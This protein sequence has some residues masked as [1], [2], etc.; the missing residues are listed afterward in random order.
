MNIPRGLVVFTVALVGIAGLIYWG[1]GGGGSVAT[2]PEQTAPTASSAA[3]AAT[4]AAPAPVPE[5][6]PPPGPTAAQLAQ[7]AL[8]AGGTVELVVI[9][10]DTATDLGQPLFT[11]GFTGRGD[12]LYVDCLPDGTVRF[13]WDHWGSQPVRS[14]AVNLAR[15]VEQRI[16]FTLGRKIVGIEPMPAE[17]RVWL[18]GA[19]VLAQA[20]DVFPCPAEQ[21]A[22]GENPTGM[23]TSQ[24]KFFGQLLG[25]EVVTGET[26]PANP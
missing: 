19:P 17:L 24:A 6:L 21:V 12:S 5:P 14:A 7:A 25:V 9:F 8:L 2:P 26:R 11:T 18:N 15:G 23:S 20:V 13:G 4:A 22:F 1:M 16:R 3:P 10:P